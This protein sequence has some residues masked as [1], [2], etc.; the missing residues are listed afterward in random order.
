MRAKEDGRNL[1]GLKDVVFDAPGSIEM[2]CPG[3]FH[4]MGQFDG[5]MV[6]IIRFWNIMVLKPEQL[7]LIIFISIQ[8]RIACLEQMVRRSLSIPYSIFHIPKQM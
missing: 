4:G 7:F 1:A 3:S 6:S 5:R 8:G 2:L